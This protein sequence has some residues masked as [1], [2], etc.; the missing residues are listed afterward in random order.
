MRRKHTPFKETSNVE[1]TVEN[2]Q[3]QPHQRHQGFLRGGFS[4]EGA[5][6]VDAQVFRQGLQGGVVGLL[7]GNPFYHDIQRIL[8]SRARLF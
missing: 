6:Q 5:G 1:E 2:F 4:T 3:A 7:G 8:H